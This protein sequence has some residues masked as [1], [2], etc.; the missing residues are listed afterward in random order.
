MSLGSRSKDMVTFRLAIKQYAIN[1]EFEL[2][3]EAT[4]TTRFRGFYQGGGCPWK[5]MHM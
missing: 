4:S 3:I 1:R 5:S 2:G